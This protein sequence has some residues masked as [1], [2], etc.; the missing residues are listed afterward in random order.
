MANLFDT[1]NAP[2]IE[3][4]SIVVGDFVQ[5]RRDD[6]AQDYSPSSYTLTYVARITGGG[7]SEIKFDANNVNGTF[8]VTLLSTTTSAFT[9]GDYHW[10][11]E[12]LRNS[13]NNRIVVDEGEF[14]TVADLDDN[15]SDPRSHAEIL[16]DKIEGLLSGR[17]DSDVSQYTIAGR[18]LTKMNL[19]ELFQA[20]DYYRREV[21]LHRQRLAKQ[22]NRDT[23]STVKVRF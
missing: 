21:Y 9:P 17:M 22:R 23:G 11:A 1:A 19:R 16:L 18:Q 5:W 4:R 12:I 6:L 20:R 14:T 13:D 7:A 10:Q 3:P 15:Q 8:F 2:T